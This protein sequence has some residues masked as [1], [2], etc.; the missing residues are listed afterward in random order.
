MPNSQFLVFWETI[1]ILTL[2]YIGTLGI[3]IQTFMD[4]NA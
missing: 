2:L 1:V 4:E 3:Y